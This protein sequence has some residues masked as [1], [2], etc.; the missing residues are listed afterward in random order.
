MNLTFTYDKSRDIWCMLHYGKG[1][2]NSSAPTKVYEELVAEYGEAPTENDI[3]AFIEKYCVRNNVRMDEYISSFQKEWN[4]VESEYHKRAEEIFG[5]TIPSDTI[6]YLTI[7]N[8]CPYDIEKNLFFVSAPGYSSTKTA[9]HE[10]WH[11]YTWYKYGKEWEP[12]LGSQRYNDIKEAL[13]VLL[14]VEYKDLLP[15]GIED[16]GYPQHKE[17]RG[18][19]LEIWSKDRNMDALWKTLV[20]EKL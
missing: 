9:M 19:I 15:G 2:N 16:W 1:S 11:F 4:S 3:S 14:N 5:V 18:K 10:F 13:T 12:K 17:L 8:R 7:N 20:S 6:A